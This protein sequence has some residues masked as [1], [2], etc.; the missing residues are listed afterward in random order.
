MITISHTQILALLPLLTIMFSVV[1]ITLFIA[2]KRKYCLTVFLSL[3]GIISSFLSLT[4]INSMIPINIFL[5]FNI[6]KIS[7]LYSG[8]VL[9]ISFYICILSTSLMSNNILNKE[10]FY[11]LL[12]F[13]TLGG[14]VLVFSSHMMTLIIGLE[15][16][17]LP[18]IGLI[19]FF[20]SNMKSIESALKYAILSILGSSFMLYGIALI[21]SISGNLGFFDIGACFN[22]YLLDKNIIFLCGLIMLLVSFGFKLSIFPFHLWISDVYKNCSS[23][24]LIFLSTVV[25]ISIISVLIHLFINIPLVVN[26]KFYFILETMAFFSIMI[27]NF[28]ALF[29]NSI[30]KIMG[31]TSISHIGLLLITFLGV[32]N[33]K[34]AIT[35]ANIYLIGHVLASIG[36]FS[37]MTSV[38]SYLNNSHEVDCLQVYKGFFW[39]FPIL[40]LAMTINICS[41]IG[42]PMTIGFWGKFY[43]IILAIQENLWVFL[44][45]LIISSIF[46]IYFGLRII[47][48][49]Y[50]YSDSLTSIKLLIQYKNYN[51]VY[52]L[53]ILFI[54][55][56]VLILGIYPQ[57]LINFIEKFSI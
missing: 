29:Q 28:M 23:L 18:L 27:G 39:R 49:I 4:F 57:I 35:S 10:E 36:V 45:A 56:F 55:S 9:F 15:L 53:F 1:I 31:Y 19:N 33:Y 6:D 25:K 13:S 32:Y 37:V 52:E 47:S 54:S 14:L 38:S 7:I 12:L 34:N 51:K 48:T 11:L 22:L 43:L 8:M 50:S 41:I 42:I 20:I 26:Q 5:L 16:L 44:V 40:A 3:I 21:Y 30:K 2:L 46:S 17:T 24:I